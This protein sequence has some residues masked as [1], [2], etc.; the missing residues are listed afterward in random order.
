MQA[1]KEMCEKILKE[2][3]EEKE[4]EDYA[5]ERLCKRRIKLLNTLHKRHEQNYE[6]ELK[7]GITKPLYKKEERPQTVSDAARF[8]LGYVEPDNKKYEDNKIVARLKK[9]RTV[10]LL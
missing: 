7:A 9:P 8:K 5:Q 3:E 6:L 4:Q 2:I 10:I 1:D